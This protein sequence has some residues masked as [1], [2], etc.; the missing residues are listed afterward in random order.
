MIVDICRIWY[1]ILYMK[2]NTD[3]P[4]ERQ[5]EQN[6][7][8]SAFAMPVAVDVV[9]ISLKAVSGTLMHD[10]KDRMESD[11]GVLES[12]ARF[13]GQSI[14]EVEADIDAELEH[15]GDA[16]MGMFAE[17]LFDKVCDGA[18]VM[19]WSQFSVALAKNH[20]AQD[21]VAK[22]PT[23]ATEALRLISLAFAQSVVIEER[24]G[25]IPEEDDPDV[26]MISDQFRRM[27]SD[28]VKFKQDRRNAKAENTHRETPSS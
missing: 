5:V 4:N 26:T 27:T 3:K 23:M 18:R 1:N 19:S 8:R 9:R 17:A 20:M 28:L 16:Y 11:Y 13:T 22:N 2:K 10:F 15:K 7:T 14:Q 25:D 21:L 24:D 12:T 6:D